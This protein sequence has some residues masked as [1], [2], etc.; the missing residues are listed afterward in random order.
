M[1]G[2]VVFDRIFMSAQNIDCVAADPQSRPRKKPFV[3][4]VANRGIGGSCAL[5]PPVTLGRKACPQDVV[6]RGPR[7]ARA[8]RH[9]VLPRLLVLISRMQETKATPANHSTR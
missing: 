1:L 5:R 3:N 6:S 2:G 9:R 8:L 4:R 7:D